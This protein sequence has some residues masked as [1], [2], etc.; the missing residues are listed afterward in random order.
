MKKILFIW[1]TLASLVSVEAQGTFQFIA[2]LNGGN[3]TPPNDSPLSAT[4]SLTLLEDYNWG[5]PGATATNSVVC[6]VSFPD[7]YFYPVAPSVFPGEV[8]LQ[9]AA[10]GDAF[11]LNL[12]EYGMPSGQ[13]FG[14]PVT[15][16]GTFEITY[17]Q[18]ADLLAGRWFLE[19]TAQIN[20]DENYPA[21]YIR[22]QITPVPEPSALA[23][24]GLGMASLF[25]ASKIKRRSS[26]LKAA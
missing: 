9:D 5:I 17:E 8:N 23:L 14:P 20:Y 12:T 11:V 16:N 26:F 22:G 4:A 25:W 6:W 19:S 1:F 21:G 7:D 13:G 3:E 18:A 2:S 15:Y 24:L 10:T